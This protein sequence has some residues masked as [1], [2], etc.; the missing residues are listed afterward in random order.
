MAVTSRI[1]HSRRGVL[2]NNIYKQVGY[3]VDNVNVVDM[4]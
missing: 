4:Y 3:A 1:N 2:E